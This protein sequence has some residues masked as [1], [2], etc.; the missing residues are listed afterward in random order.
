MISRE[1]DIRLPL[2]AMFSR[3]V[4]ELFKIFLVFYV[5]RVS[6]IFLLSLSSF[7]PSSS[8]SI[9]SLFFHAAVRLVFDEEQDFFL[10]YILAKRI[11]RLIDPSLT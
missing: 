5:N 4:L 6:F 7:F 9:Q 8:S 11:H 10:A 3:L 1:R 2:S